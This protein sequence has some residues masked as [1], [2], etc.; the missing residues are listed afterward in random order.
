MSFTANK[1]A[2]VLRKQGYK[3]T[4]QRRAILTAMALSNE[5]LTPSALF[6]R[7][8]KLQSS[9]GLVTI[10]RTLDILVDLG[11]VCRVHTGNNSLS[12]IMRRPS[13]HHHHLICSKCGSVVDFIDC[14]LTALEKSLTARTGFK[15]EN[16]LLEFSGCCRDCH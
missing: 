8:N 10:Y 16:H 9:I 1:I 4:P 11:L 12:Y 3:L 2:S 14:D 5:H 6:T 13:E 15:I 7:V